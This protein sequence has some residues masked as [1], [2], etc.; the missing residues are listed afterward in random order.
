MVSFSSHNNVNRI[1]EK[2]NIKDWGRNMAALMNVLKD[3]ENPILPA[4][5]WIHLPLRPSPPCFNNQ[6]S[7]VINDT[8]H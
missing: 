5:W 4:D 3:Q 2:G 7:N 6:I 1:P 8:M